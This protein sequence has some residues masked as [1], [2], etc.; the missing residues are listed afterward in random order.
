MEKLRR[1]GL[2]GLV[3]LLLA[4]FWAGLWY[5]GQRLSL[6]HISTLLEW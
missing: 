5:Q 3:A 6:I 4:C 1:L 2:F